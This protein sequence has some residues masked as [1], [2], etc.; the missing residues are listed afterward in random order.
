[1]ELETPGKSLVIGGA[2]CKMCRYWM[3]HTAANLALY[4]LSGNTWGR[5][6]NSTNVS[7]VLKDE[8]AMQETSKDKSNVDIERLN[9]ETVVI[10]TCE[11]YVCSNFRGKKEEKKDELQ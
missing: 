9:E 11:S 5:C 10:S 2:G 1:M 8:T 3:R 6:L 4:R 7:N